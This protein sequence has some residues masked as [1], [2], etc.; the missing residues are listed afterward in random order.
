MRIDIFPKLVASVLSLCCLMAA[1]VLAEAQETDSDDG[2]NFK[3]A[4]YLWGAGIDGTTQRGNEIDVTFSDIVSNLDMAFM[5]AF[6]ARRSKWSLVADAVYLDVSADQ[7]GT[8]GASSIP[9]NADASVQGWVLN[10][11]GARNVFDS[12]RASVGV[13]AGARYLD[14]DSKLNLR[15]GAAGPTGS[16]SASASVWDGVVG[17][18]GNVN[19][20]EQWYLPYYADVGTGQSDLTWQGLAG[21]GYRF[22]PVD[23]VLTY[24]HIHWDF[25]SDSAFS[26]LT[27]SGPAL[28]VVFK[29]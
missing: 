12:D 22:K 11:H 29:F 23:V 26:D 18:K 28:G 8:I 25:K 3:M 14:A 9:Y 2:W 24:R 4:I 17:V 15:L 1:P 19:I 10:L 7:A 5:G 6:E 21:V 27:F 20:T 16:A 13:L